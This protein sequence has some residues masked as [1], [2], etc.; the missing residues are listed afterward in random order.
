MPQGNVRID[1]SNWF[2]SRARI[3]L[4]AINDRWVYDACLGTTY[5]VAT[6]VAGIP[7]AWGNSVRGASGAAI[8]TAA[9]PPDLLMSKKI[10]HVCWLHGRATSWVANKAM[11]LFDVSS[12]SGLQT[13]CFY[14]T[15]T[16]I[17]L[18]SLTFG[19]TG[20]PN[21]I[22]ALDPLSPI[23]IGQTYDAGA[24]RLFASSYGTAGVLRGTDTVTADADA[25]GTDTRI[26]VF[27][28]TSQNVDYGGAIWFAGALTDGE[29][30]EVMRNPWQC[31]L[32]ETYVELAAAGAP[33][34]DFPVI[35]AAL[36]QRDSLNT[37]LR[38]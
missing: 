38:L 1:P 16:E 5:R 13:H 24:A 32:P 37:L 26:D 18:Q 35:P 22:I 7:S 30:A 10:S 23:I 11:R 12:G 6:T 27:S 2:G 29:M 28:S 20:A 36:L 8:R 15:S 17:N 19:D 14:Q 4:Y 34:S 31:L 21:L 3:F 33:A 9:C 25:S